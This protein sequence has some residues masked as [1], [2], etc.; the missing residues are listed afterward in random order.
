MHAIQHLHLSWIA[1]H[2]LIAVFR[3]SSFLCNNSYNL[4]A[5]SSRFYIIERMWE[6]SWSAAQIWLN[7]WHDPC[8]FLLQMA[9]PWARLGWV[10]LI[11]FDWLQVFFLCKNNNSYNF[12]AASSRFYIIERVWETSWSSALCISNFCHD[13]CSVLLQMAKPWARLGLVELIHFDWLLSHR[14]RC[15][16]PPGF[17]LC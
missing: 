8:S 5:G 17:R 3:C 12:T 9:K 13:Q 7:F 6:T 16:I 1:G 14:F 10:E 2:L 11:H 4:S 15:V